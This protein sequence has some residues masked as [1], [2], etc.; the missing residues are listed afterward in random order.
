MPEFD[1]QSQNDGAEI[2]FKADDQQPLRLELQHFLD[3]IENRATPISDGRNGV[4]V[5]TA[6]ERI[7]MF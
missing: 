7:M 3:C 1:L 6:L 5:I 2:L 4:E